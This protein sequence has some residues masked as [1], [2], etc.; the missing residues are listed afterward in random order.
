MG[1]RLKE[2]HRS[3]LAKKEKFKSQIEIEAE[4]ITL[5]MKEC[6]RRGVT[7]FTVAT[8]HPEKLAHLLDGKKSGQRSVEFICNADK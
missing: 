8:L 5:Y 3:H 4:Q 2:M 7:K 1:D 6:S